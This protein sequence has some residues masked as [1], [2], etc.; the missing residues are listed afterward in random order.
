MR[1]TSGSFHEYHS[2]FLQ[3]M[4]DRFHDLCRKNI[5]LNFVTIFYILIT[6]PQHTAVGTDVTS[7]N[8]L[9]KCVENNSIRQFI[10]STMGSGQS[11][12]L[13]MIWT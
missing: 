5:S 9:E 3:S 1:Q 7:A 2:L 6:L 10:H 11:T 12:V 13:P 8:F 4:D